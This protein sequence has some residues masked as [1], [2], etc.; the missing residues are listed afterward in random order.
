MSNKELNKK[1]IKYKKTASYLRFIGCGNCKNF[2]KEKYRK[3]VIGICKYLNIKNKVRGGYLCKYFNF[4]E[5][6]NDE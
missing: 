3:Q 2:T 1:Q 5:I 4:K 6:K